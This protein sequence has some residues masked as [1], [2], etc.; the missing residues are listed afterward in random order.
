MTIMIERNHVSKAKN[1]MTNSKKG[2]VKALFQE[3]FSQILGFVF[4]L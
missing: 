1:V 4:Q 3:N 2:K